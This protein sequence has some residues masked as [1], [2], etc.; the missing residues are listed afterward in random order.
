MS[1][2]WAAVILQRAKY[3]V[4]INLIPRSAQEA[5]A[6]ITAYIVPV[7]RHHASVYGDVGA[8]RAGFQDC[9]RDLQRRAGRNAATVI[10]VDGAVIDGPAAIEAATGERRIIA[11]KSAVSECY[12][13]RDPAAAA[14]RLTIM[15]ANG[16][17]AANCAAGDR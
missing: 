3:R 7:R 5:A 11:A 15:P 10:V 6:V 17:V 13:A 12:A 16:S 8:P 4:G 9:I 1:K 14:P 2:G